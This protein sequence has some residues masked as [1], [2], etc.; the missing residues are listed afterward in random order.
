[1]CEGFGV[2]VDRGLNVWFSEQDY[3]G[4]CSHSTTLEHL[5]WE[6]NA[7]PFLRYFVRVQFPDWTAVSFE[8]DEEDTLPGWAEANRAEIQD[9]CIKVLEKH[10]PAGAEYEKVRDAAGA[11]YVKVRDAARAEYEKVCDAALAEYEKVLAAAWAEFTQAF[12]AIPGYV[13]A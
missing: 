7:D 13:G 2:I 1:M 9:R 12:A 5:G 3:G 10:A 11:E 4:D 6:D 8:F